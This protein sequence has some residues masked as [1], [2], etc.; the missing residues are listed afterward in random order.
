MALYTIGVRTTNITAGNASC[1]LYTAATLGIRIWEIGICQLA[2]AAAVYGLGRPQAQGITPVPANFQAEQ[3]TAD[4]SAK[5]NIS[6]SWGTG[7]TTP[8]AFMRRAGT[9]LATSGVYWTFPRG[10]YVPASGSIVI[11]NITAG[12]AADVYF[13]IDE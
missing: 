5:T 7:P 3:S 4:P 8:L 10:L 9:A 1:E 6:L 13:V 2:A 12:S 11:W